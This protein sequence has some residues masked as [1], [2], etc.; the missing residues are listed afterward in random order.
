MSG[1]TAKLDAKASELIACSALVVV[2]LCVVFY[3]VFDLPS[4][5]FFG[6]MDSW[7]SS[8]PQLFLLD[9]HLQ[10]DKAIP[11]W[12]FL[13]LCGEPFLPSLTGLPLYPPN[14]V[15]SILTAN[16]TPFKTQLSFAL[17]AALHFVIGGTGIYSLA[18]ARGSSRAAG[19]VA[20]LVF[21]FNV[22]YISRSS[23]HFVATFSIAWLPWVILALGA[24]ME[25]RTAKG[26]VFY[27]LWGAVGL[28]LILL[29]GSGNEFTL[30]MG[31]CVAS[32]VGLWHVARVDQI[33]RLG[34][35]YF[36]TLGSNV[37]VAGVAALVAVL[38]GLVY[39]LVPLELKPY[40]TR[41]V[42][43]D[44]FEP[45]AGGALSLG[46]LIRI[47]AAWPGEKSIGAIHGAGTCAFFL[48]LWSVF[49]RKRREVL[50]F[51]L[52]FYAMLDTAL[53]PPMPI[54]FFVEQLSPYPLGST[55]RAG[56][57]A[58]LPMAILAGLGFDALFDRSSL[59]RWNRFARMTAALLLAA[60]ALWLLRDGMADT[61]Y[62]SF[63]RAVSVGPI[64][65]VAI[66]VVGQVLR[67]PL[68]LR[69]L[70][71][72]FMATEIL[73]WSYFYNDWRFG[74]ELIPEKI[75]DLRDE[76]SFPTT[77]SRNVDEQ[78]NRNQFF[79]RPIHNGYDPACLYET[80]RVL[81]AEGWEDEYH[82]VIF[83][84]GPMTNLRAS[85][86]LKR[87]AWL[88][89]QYV[90]GPLPERNVP[91]PT[92]SIV[93]LQGVEGS[94]GIPRVEAAAVPKTSISPEA[95]RES[96]IERSDAICK[97]MKGAAGNDPKNPT[98]YYRFPRLTKPDK[99]CAL[100]MRLKSS[101][102]VECLMSIENPTVPGNREY[103]YLKYVHVTGAPEG[104][105]FEVPLP[106]YKQFVVGMSAIP[107]KGVPPDIEFLDLY[108]L[109]DESDEDYLIQSIE[110]T[111]RS[112]SMKI[113]ELPGPRVLTFLD[114]YF[115]GWI[116]FVDGERVP[117]YKA[118]DAFKAVA[119]DKGSH[120]VKF[121]FKSR[122]YT[123]GLAGSVIGVLGTAAGL[124]LC[125][126]RSRDLAAHQDSGA[127]VGT[128]L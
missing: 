3:D 98:M 8:G 86:L 46:R 57:V 12:N 103:S 115:P 108:F 51:A 106:D 32:F 112:C 72:V 107:Q 9:Y 5:R 56:L 7:R 70:G 75:A 21:L 26:K 20:M 65:F 4:L 22:D 125:W 85:M 79:L 15:R 123:I 97:S 10:K 50:L 17:L 110:F 40:T 116:A 80:Y 77:N 95:A 91:F 109:A 34:G 96:R 63:S 69:S 31:I 94:I 64:L 49:S 55:E 18:R 66:A 81:A 41:I 28:G 39:V 1:L 76:G 43:G 58:L 29:A 87:F 88:A 25:S 2:L 27:S 101:G 128:G 104:D 119:L 68:A 93:F 23:Q 60:G 45:V 74:M 6:H 117:L 105:L 121:V 83:K 100:M 13:T 113:G 52:L 24:A 16:P 44:V 118:D 71:V 42:L 14:L 73:T 35:A 38:I 99:H 48:A 62:F 19:I 37:A 124:I 36:R 67:M 30:Y 126:P 11:L 47:Y 111:G 120:E 90:E 78:P 59:P 53:G 33:G 54:S 84:E 102:P 122:T 89:K 92:A 114:S 127:R 82:R 61:R